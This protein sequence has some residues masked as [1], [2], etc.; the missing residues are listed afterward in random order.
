MKTTHT[1]GM[2]AWTAT[3][4]FEVEDGLFESH[5]VGPGLNGELIATVRCLGQE[6]VEKRSR[7]IKAAPAL[8]EALRNMI[9]LAVA[10]W[11]AMEDSPLSDTVYDEIDAA[12]AALALV[13]GGAP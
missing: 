3:M 1:P 6:N 8:Y 11:E 10:H 9:G 7:I 4:A 13:E 2:E 12:R 5:I